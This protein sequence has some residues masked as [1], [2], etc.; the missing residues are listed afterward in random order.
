MERAI[1]WWCDLVGVTS[2]PAIHVAVGVV[3]AA[4]FLIAAA[5]AAFLIYTFVYVLRN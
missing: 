1:N 3:A 4:S 2:E 5:V